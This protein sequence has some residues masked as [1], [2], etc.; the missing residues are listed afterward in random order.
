MSKA[1]AQT[2]IS[3]RL[4]AA[5]AADDRDAAARLLDEGANPAAS[6]HAAVITAAAAGRL[7]ILELFLADRGVNAGSNKSRALREA[8]ANGHVA[9][10][11]RL[12]TIST[13]DVGAASNAALRSAAARGHAAVVAVLLADAGVDPAAES[14]EALWAAASNGHADV[15][16]LLL[17]DGRADPTACKNR[18]IR[19]AAAKGHAAVVELLLAVP[20][21][22]PGAGNSDAL[23]R[24]A[25]SG[26]TAVVAQLL[27]SKRVDPAA[28]GFEAFREAVRRAHDEVV[29]LLLDPR[30]CRSF[31]QPRGSDLLKAIADTIDPSRMFELRDFEV[32]PV[33]DRLLQHEHLPVAAARE[34][35][36]AS[37]L[38]NIFDLSLS[39]PR[40][41]GLRIKK[42]GL[43]AL[44]SAIVAGDLHAITT[45]L[46]LPDVDPMSLSRSD[47]ARLLQFSCEISPP[48]QAQLL[49]LIA[50]KPSVKSSPASA[51][52][53]LYCAAGLQQWRRAEEI[54]AEPELA[55]DLSPAAPRWSEGQVRAAEWSS[56][57]LVASVYRAAAG[58]NVS[59]M[60]RLLDY[61]GIRL[62]PA[63]RAV[64]ASEALRGGCTTG[65]IAVLEALLSAGRLRL[66]SHSSRPIRL[67]ARYGQLDLLEWLLRSDA[68]PGVDPAAADNEPLRIAAMYGHVAVVKRL[69]EDPRVDPTVGANYAAECAA[70]SLSDPSWLRICGLLLGEVRAWMVK[71]PADDF[72]HSVL[73][74]FNDASDSGSDNGSAHSEGS[75]GADGAVGPAPARPLAGLP[76][77]IVQVLRGGDA[78]PASA[79]T[80]APLWMRKAVAALQAQPRPRQPWPP[81]RLLLDAVKLPRE[82]DAVLRMRSAGIMSSVVHLGGA[83][84]LRRRAAVLGRIMYE[85]RPLHTNAAAAAGTATTASRLAL[86][87]PY[88]LL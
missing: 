53:R 56:L 9:V 13:V 74:T 60:N 72:E 65:Q 19:E 40:F 66:G 10:V 75:D 79:S 49:K 46:A 83:A 14:S 44:A 85:L 37:G 38:A 87:S 26:H 88:I 43:R 47:M 59:I 70:D 31:Q 1:V 63:I 61:P 51:P 7:A 21:V 81:L 73:H 34:L 69:L 52:L 67:A 17:M 18:A 48:E 20:A 82:H 71:P 39:H 6:S 32:P 84:W 78:A 8:S 15:V 68:P 45:P 12:L 28:E 16:A 33:L 22:D 29:A 62:S 80:D 41:R 77:W 24:A 3:R 54:M 57:V 35:L 55:R 4:I 23:R 30:L 76:D 36:M 5:V 11:R 27:A 2:T 25:A 42:P 86:K 58:G 64:A 50:A